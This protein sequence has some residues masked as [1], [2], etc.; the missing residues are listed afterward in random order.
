MK[1]EFSVEEVVKARYSVRTYTSEAISVE[2]INQI[3]EYIKTLSNP[4]AVKVNFTLLETKNLAD[5]KKLGTYGVIK[6]SNNYIGATVAKGDLA[7]EALGYEFEKLVLYLTSMGLGTCWLGGTFDRNSFANALE[8]NEKEL[9]PII[10]PLGY[11]ADKKR[12]AET[13]ARKIAKADEREPWNKLFFHKDFNKSLNKENAGIYEFVLEMVR[14][15]PSA[16]NKQPWRIVQE[17][18]LYHFYKEKAKRS[19]DKVAYDVKAIDMGIAAC[20]FHLAALEKDLTGEFKKLELPVID[21]PENYNYV[22]SW[23]SL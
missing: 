11:A 22:F 10:S 3:K 4:F 12:F 20:H 9:F 8:V 19:S 5:T 13:L 17:G 1:L 16:V 7:L 23:V 15:A 6:G 14:L 21:T 2:K 18:K